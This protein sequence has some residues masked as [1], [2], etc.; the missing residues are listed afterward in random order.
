MNIFAKQKQTHRYRK[1]TCSHQ[2]GERRGGQIKGTRLT[3]NIQTINTTY[4][5]D[6]QQGYTVQHR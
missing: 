1:Q 5:I 3:S 4:K 2:K 6:K